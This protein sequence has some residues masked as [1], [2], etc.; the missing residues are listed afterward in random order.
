MA[1]R[2]RPRKRHR[3]GPDAASIRRRC[4]AGSRG[5][6]GVD[7]WGRLGVPRGRGREGGPAWLRRT[8]REAHP[9]P[10]W[11]LPSV[12]PPLARRAWPILLGRHG[13]PARPPTTERRTIWRQEK[14]QDEHRAGGTKGLRDLVL[15]GGRELLRMWGSAQELPVQALVKQILC[16]SPSCTSV[17]LSPL[18]LTPLAAARG[19]RWQIRTPC[20]NCRRNRRPQGHRCKWRLRGALLCH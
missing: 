9:A 5:R 4:N 14:R 13:R 2:C 1:C 8:A 16:G 3:A 17:T 6:F 12:S 20:T 18:D 15:L 7:A 19:H 10:P 11:R